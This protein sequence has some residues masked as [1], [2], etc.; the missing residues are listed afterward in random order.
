MIV[1]WTRCW[2][3]LAVSAL[4][5]RSP[6]RWA[7]LNPALASRPARCDAERVWRV[8]WSASLHHCKRITCLEY[9]AALHRLLKRRGIDCTLRIG[10][11]P[12]S[13]DSQPVDAHAWV[14][15]A[16]GTP[17][18]DLKPWADYLPLNPG[19]RA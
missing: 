2:W 7:Y 8:L 10:V 11:R 9:A 13:D 16:D 18:W 17:L 5:I 4:A 14:E 12:P 6:W 3:E 19:R 1:L 15:L